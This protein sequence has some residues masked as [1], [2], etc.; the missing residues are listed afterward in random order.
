MNNV[1]NY[2]IPDLSEI[3][4]SSFYKFI[5][6]GIKNELLNFPNPFFTNITIK[7][8]KVNSLVYLYPNDIKIK[9]PT[10][11]MSECFEKNIS[12][13]IQ[14]YIPVEYNYKLDNK[15][16]R[17]KQDMFLAEIPL[18]TEEG[19]FIINGCEKIIISQIIRSPGIYFKKEYNNNKILFVATI[20]SD[21]GSW[22]KIILDNESKIQD[23]LDNFTIKFT[24]SIE[25]IVDSSNNKFTIFD[26]LKFF[27]INSNE[28]FDNLKYS[29]HLD[30]N[31]FNKKSNF[32]IEFD[33]FNFI[34][35]I[36]FNTKSGCLS[37]GELGRYNFNKKLNINLPKK[38]KT[39]TSL[40]FLKIID[41]LLE[42]KYYNKLNDDIDNIK[43]K[44]IRSVGDLIQNQFR[45]GLFRLE[46]NLIYEDCTV[47]IQQINLD[48]DNKIDKNHLL[49]DPRHI[50]SSIK[51]FFN[52]SQLSQFM[53]QINPLSEMTHKRKIS[54]FGPNGLKRDH[55]STSIRDIQ[56][57]HYGKICPIE[58]PEGQNAG[59]I[60]SISLYSRINFLG[61]LETPYFIIKDLKIRNNKKVFYLNSEQEENISIAVDD[62]FLKNN[63]VFKKY[64]STK[65][66]NNFILKELKDINFITT[67]PNQIIS[68]ATNLIPF[69]EH[70]DPN[71]ALMGSNMQRQAVPL[72]YNQ[73]A[74]VGTGFESN[75]I[76][77]S[78][79]ILKN[80][81]EGT[82]ILASNRFIKIK[83]TFNQLITYKLKK[84]LK[85]NQETCINQQSIVWP[86]EY[87]FSGQIIADGPSTKD[88]ELALGRNLIL[89]YMPWEG[90]NYEDAIIIN[91][92]LVTNNIL[93][94]IHIEEI[95]VEINSSYT[96][97]EKLTNK[98]PYISNFEVRNLNKN[99]IVKLGSYVFPN[100]ILVGKLTKIE[101]EISP[102]VKLLRALYT[103]EEE[104]FKNTSFRVPNTTEGRVIDI[105]IILNKS[106]K[107]ND[108]LGF[109]LKKE[110]IR[111]YIAQIRKIQIGDKLA[112]RHGNKGIVSKI[113]SNQ[114]MPFLPNGKTIDIIFN[115]LGVPSRMNVGQVFESL[116]GLSSLKLGK[117]FKIQPFDE[118]FGNEASRILINQKNKESVYSEKENWYFNPNYTG[119]ILLRDG[120]NGE[121]FDNPIT[122]GVSYIIKLIHL[123]EDKIHSRSVGPYSMINE[124]PLAGKAQNGGQRFGEM[125][126]WALEA[127]GSSNT[128]Q[129]ILTIKSDD[130][131]GRTDIYDSIIFNNKI[132]K[133]SINIPE[134]F[135]ALIRELNALG[136]DLSLKKIDKFFDI[137]LDLKEVDKDLF[138]ELE[139]RLNLR[140]LLFYKKYQK[141]INNKENNLKNAFNKFKE[142][143]ILLKKLGI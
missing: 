78:G 96:N 118:L 117:R 42:L 49:I 101:D 48:L 128:L 120:R 113:L 112:G 104:N 43:N 34:K 4:H 57:S 28:I 142:S 3:Q 21:K 133:P 41:S 32:S 115:P 136:L 11:S 14:L 15:I 83:D 27:G 9:G 63:K 94:S 33:T 97:Y 109:E 107:E 125:E 36:F 135:T 121:Y 56:T 67:I 105:R 51:E 26:L 18:M 17:L 59:L 25:N 103:N 139:E 65:F 69:V 119:K 90:Y 123:V 8:H 85:S 35:N 58:T 22:T 130:I 80:Y 60:N 86:G 122:V 37:I 31:I 124:Q 38:I 131:D 114:D 110:I 129:E 95:D 76:C 87:V 10:F 68:L 30:K 5:L 99:G 52:L 20:I 1:F 126:V 61:L 75:A 19:T 64:I 137:S 138:K 106:K 54:L 7:K 79:M 50:T 12:Y 143:S 29:K 53:D 23:S 88:G 132:E 55:I 92:N 84:Y 6:Q 2:N 71:R 62:L 108:I 91:E 46:R 73:K 111:I 93:T 102:E 141:K 72:L 140:N 127:F 70:N 44:Q 100:D 13:S 24:D 16:V 89:A 134:S 81:C 39:L 40:D 116:L 47:N 98:L 82:V 74:I 66:N 45:I 77:D